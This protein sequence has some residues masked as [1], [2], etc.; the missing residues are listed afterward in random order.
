LGMKTYQNPEILRK[1]YWEDR[2]SLSGIGRIFGVTGGTILYNMKLLSIPR[3]KRQHVQEPKVKFTKNMLEELYWKQKLTLEGIA[4]KH[5]VSAQLIFK[6]MKIFD[7]S[8]RNSHKKI[9]RKALLEELYIKKRLP[10]SKIA[11]LLDFNPR[12]VRRLLEK[13]GIKSRS[14]SEALTKKQK[15][16]FSKNQKEKAYLLGLRSG[17]F[18][19][20]TQHKT[21]RVQT[22]TTHPAQIELARRSF[23][24][25]S[26]VNIYEFFNKGFNAKEW[27]VYVDLN[28]SFSFLLN[29]PDKIPDWIMNEE[30][31][32]FSYLA[33]YIDCEGH[34]WIA[35]SHEDYIRFGL[36]LSTQDRNILHQITSKLTTLGYKTHIYLS[37]E[38]NTIRYGV[39]N[40]KDLF[41]VVVYRKGDVIK[42]AKEL[43]RLSCHQEK[44][45]RMNLMI[46]SEH[47]KWDEI[48]DKLKLLRENMKRTRL[49]SLQK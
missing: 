48:K 4:K 23:G 27:F 33:G 34:W 16:D 31:L 40:N 6:Y 47:K 24:K 42:L 12:Y 20:K 36:R 22:T 21:V 17:D 18:H 7:V 25:Y 3:E 2:L 30:H 19:A 28:G 38:G 13:N 32:F 41:S 5:G 14:V 39:K 46:E 43:L 8:R 10:S 37:Q 35:K 26:Q 1:L 29:K 15:L 44:I 45:E 9:D 11:K 49:N